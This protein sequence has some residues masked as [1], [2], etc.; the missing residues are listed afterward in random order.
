VASC[1]L[2][3]SEDRAI[4]VLFAGFSIG[5]DF[6]DSPFKQGF[7]FVTAFPAIRPILSVL[8]A[9]LVMTNSPHGDSLIRAVTR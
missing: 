7:V 3:D 2:Y 5:A 6:A 4:C 1:A 8:D 9:A